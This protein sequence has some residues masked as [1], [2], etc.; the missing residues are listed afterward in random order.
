MISDFGI[1]PFFSFLLNSFL[2]R[3]NLL[4]SIIFLLNIVSFLLIGGFSRCLT[5]YI[6]TKHN[7]FY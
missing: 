3:Y 1:I 5:E 4:C 2:I 6:S 7:P